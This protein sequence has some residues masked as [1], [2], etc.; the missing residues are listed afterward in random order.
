MKQFDDTAG[1]I[2]FEGVTKRYGSV[3][4]LSDV[5]VSFRAGITGLVGLN[6][7]GKTTLIKILFRL[8]Q[9][10]AGRVM[11]LGE[12]TSR[13]SAAYRNQLGYVPED[14][15]FLSG[16]TGIEAVH[17]AAR[18]AGLPRLEGL[19]RAHEILD[20]C[21]VQQERYRLVE[22]YS[23][24]MRQKIKF[25]QA[26]VH[27]PPLLVLDEPTSG[28][29]PQERQAMLNR[30]VT[31]SRKFGK[32][33]VMSTHILPDIE[34]VC[35]HLVLIHRGRICDEGRLDELLRPRDASW[36]IEVIE[37]T[38][39]FRD[40]LAAAGFT[41]TETEQQTWHLRGTESDPASLYRIAQRTGAVLRAVRPARWSLERY[42][43]DLVETV[44]RDRKTP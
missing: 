30:I 23:T 11:V 15:C 43:V 7:A 18:M 31:L 29:D 5:T 27:D 10:T 32:S 25:A 40:E 16:L 14:D 20:F 38:S 42:F 22:T 6:G 24:G 2:T 9:P 33:I 34:Q 21:G 1:L 39:D 3:T 36:T 17:F 19:R 4:A 13:W 35:D 28:L 41:M 44:E 8:I 12:E 26:I 37:G